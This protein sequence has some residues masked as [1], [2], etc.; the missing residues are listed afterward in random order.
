MYI[1]DTHN[2]VFPEN[3]A[4]RA[5]EALSVP[6]VYEP[7]YDGT[8]AGL[9]RSMDNHGIARAWT[10]PVAT[11]ASQV[12]TINAYAATQPRDR[13]TPLGAIH[14]DTENPREV[15]SHFSEMGLVGFKMHPDYQSFKPTDPRLD[16]IWQAAVDYNLICYFHA[17]DD[18]NPRTKN[19]TPAEF[20][21]ILD[22]H[23]SVLLVLAHFGGYKMWDEVE[24]ILV[25]R[26]VWFDTA[27]MAEHIDREQFL[28]MAKAHGYNRI[29]FATDGPWTDP[30]VALD[31]IFNT[32]LADS[33]LEQI[34]HGTAEALLERAGI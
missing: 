33:D 5:I 32:G 7:H 26:N 27:Y 31:F 10:V 29:M 25:G 2:H 28:R 4:A 15:L 3:L 18:E 21:Q 8:C 9:L 11:R 24:E 19:G 14:P 23:P 12:E 34:F 20:A 1:I 30:Q 17:G 6:I 22:R 13:I 16:E